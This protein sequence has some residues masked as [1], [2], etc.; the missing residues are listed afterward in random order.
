MPRSLVA[1]AFATIFA[2]PALASDFSFLAKP[3][4]AR[5]LLMSPKQREEMVCTEGWVSASADQPLAPL[6]AEMDD[7]HAAALGSREFVEKRRPM[8]D[9]D[10]I[11]MELGENA[12]PPAGPSLADRRKR[13]LA[14]LPPRCAQ[15]AA[16]FTSGGLSAAAALIAPRPASVIAL[17]ST[18]HC[19]KQL[20]Y[21]R[22]ARDDD[23]FV[24]DVRAV[25]A[26]VKTSLLIEAEE[27]GAIERDYAAF[28]PPAAKASRPGEDWSDTE[29]NDLICF[30]VFADISARLRG[31]R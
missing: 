22:L 24:D 5:S 6:I 19:L 9:E 13:R 28:T 23:G 18:G 25:R 1:V 8:I 29:L 17:P 31:E 3:E 15:L 10:V 27:K 7:R 20:E 11:D 26:Q 2:A 16:A 4:F 30:P 14:E 12:A 21:G